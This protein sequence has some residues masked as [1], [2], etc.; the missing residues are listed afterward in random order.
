MTRYVANGGIM[1]PELHASVTLSPALSKED[2]H[3]FIIDALLTLSLV[4]IGQLCDDGC[5]AIFQNTHYRYS[6]MT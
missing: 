4:S 3:A 1:T 5:I 6:R 2:K